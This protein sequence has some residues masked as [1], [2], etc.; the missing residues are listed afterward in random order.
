MRI[1]EENL[2][3]ANQE[4]HKKVTATQA[5]DLE[6]LKEKEKLVQRDEELRQAESHMQADT[7]ALNLRKDEVQ[8]RVVQ[9]EEGEAELKKRQEDFEVVADGI[10]K[11]KEIVEKQVS[12]N[13]KYEHELNDLKAELKAQENDLRSR[14]RRVG[15]MLHDHSEREKTLQVEE[16]NMRRS[17]AE[18]KSKQEEMDAASDALNAREDALKAREKAVEATQEKCVQRDEWN[19]QRAAALDRKE[20]DLANWMK[21]MEWREMILGDREA[22]I[23]REPVTI[24]T[25]FTSTTPYSQKAFGHA[26]VEVQL[27]RLKDQYV[28][29][30]MKHAREELSTGKPKYSKRKRLPRAG[31][32]TTHPAGED[33]AAEIS[34]VAE[35]RSLREGVHEMSLSFVHLMSRIRAFDGFEDAAS[36]EK[37]E[38]LT[39]FNENERTAL[40]MAANLEY[41]LRVYEDFFVSLQQSPFEEK[42]KA[43]D[44]QD[45]INRLT[46]W[47]Q[48]QKSDLYKC[49]M[50]LLSDRRKYL[51]HALAIL[52]S[53]ATNFPVRDSDPKST[54]CPYSANSAYEHVTES[55]I[56]APRGLATLNAVSAA[57]ESNERAKDRGLYEVEMRPSTTPL[58]SKHT[59]VALTAQEQQRGKFSTAPPDIELSLVR[60]GRPSNPSREGAK[61][62]L[63]S[64]K[65]RKLRI[66]SAYTLPNAGVSFH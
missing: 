41:L 2:D 23:D 1:R 34:R 20:K 57:A 19:T 64:V 51:S 4:L 18:L 43:A 52:E 61:F 63:A 8:R 50:Q 15:V 60:T 25:D 62:D 39:F 42:D 3:K 36:P 26:T 45:L 48:H 31:I 37:L 59:L 10:T 32:A 35:L 66:G 49:L 28:S 53:K 47:W 55:T 12:E 11:K 56:L 22:V 33:V 21:E 44:V 13:K 27:R 58:S 65:L 5:H 6:I 40:C 16:E 38:H 29:A 54:P 24:Q 7:R 46:R 9:L 30:Q 17:L 14:E